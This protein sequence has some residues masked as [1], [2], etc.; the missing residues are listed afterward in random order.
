MTR[1]SQW[2]TPPSRHRARQRTSTSAVRVVALEAAIKSTN[3]EADATGSA[4]SGAARRSRSTVP[5]WPMSE[6]VMWVVQVDL[7]SRA[8]AAATSLAGAFGLTVNDAIV[9]QNSNTLALRLLPCDVFART[10]LGQEAAAFEVRL[11]RRLAA[12]TGPVASLDPRVEPRLHEIDGFAITFW[13]YYDATPDPAEPADYAVA[14]RWL[15]AAMRDVQIEAPHFMERRG[16]GAHC[17]E[18]KRE[19]RAG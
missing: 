1:T 6:R 5:I 19:P 12:V 7:V 4:A 13:T 9:I 16:G 3:R 18:P 8:L 2:P 17:H 14:L 11:A 15:H 10:L